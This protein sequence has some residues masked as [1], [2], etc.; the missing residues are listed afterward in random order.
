MDWKRSRFCQQGY[1]KRFINFNENE[2]LD[3]WYF[4]LDVNGWLN[5]KNGIPL[6]TVSYKDTVAFVRDIPTT[7][8]DFLNG[9]YIRQD[10]NCVFGKDQDGH[11]DYL[12]SCDKHVFMDEKTLDEK[13]LS[14]KWDAGLLEIQTMEIEKIDG[15]MESFILV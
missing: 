6:S 11:D 12:I 9:F 3:K 4:T 14:R 5:R 7:L 2:P 13:I 10:V 15:D 8:N 1:S